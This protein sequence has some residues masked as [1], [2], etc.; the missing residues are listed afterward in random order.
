MRVAVVDLPA[1]T[2]PY[3]RS[4]CAGLA[5]AGAEVTLLTSRFAHGEVPPADGFEV[6]EPFYRR[7]AATTGRV[8]RPLRAAEHLLSLAALRR[9]AEGFD[10]VHYQWLGFPALDSLL[11]PPLRPRV[12]TPHGWLREEGSAARGATGFR[13]LA[14]AMDK[15]VAL[16]DW[17]ARRLRD[18]LGLDAGRVEVVP[19]GAFDYLTRLPDE[20]PLP[21][22]FAGVERPVVLCFGLIR[23]YKG[24]DL[25]IEAFRDVP[26]AELWIVGRPLGTPIE[27]LRA[28]AAPIAGR[29]R[30]EPRFVPERELPAFFRRA[31]VVVLPY[32]D[33]EQS[34]VLFTALAFGKA[35]V[36][37]DVGGFG[38][39]AA[40]GAA[41]AVPPADAAELSGAIRG[42]LADPA[43]RQKLEEGARAAA[44]GPYSW[45][46]VAAQM[47]S[48]YGS[49]RDGG[50]R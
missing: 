16:S 43:A 40:A 33:A 4:L 15:V 9:E 23:P 25:L 18:R 19:H 34:G 50:P 36:V 30:I 32:R 12:L 26:D 24:V 8:R 28:L 5:R 22:P 21:A 49:L 45:D 48:I 1:Y 7:S 2:P 46:A 31:D 39:V 35:I 27:P 29:V 37:T 13:R 38:E 41:R 44:A 20:A 11:L 3:D 6:R 17:G 42:L 14:H 10:L 47:L